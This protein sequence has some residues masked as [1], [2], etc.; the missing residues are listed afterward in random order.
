MNTRL[1]R[2]RREGQAG[3]AWPRGDHHP[4]EEGGTQAGELHPKASAG[5]RH[6]WRREFTDT[7]QSLQDKRTGGQRREGM[8]G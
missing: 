4:A 8:S 5:R 2:V 7:L 6:A 1:Q 3:L